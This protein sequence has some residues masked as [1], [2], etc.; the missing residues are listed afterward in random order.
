[1][2]NS[3]YS[4]IYAFGDSLS[5]DGNV[6]IASTLAG[7]P[8]PASPPY[9]LQ[10]YGLFTA[11]E[12]SDGPVWVQDLNGLLGLPTLEPSLFFGNDF[13]Y[14]GA[15]ATVNSGS[16]SGLEQSATSLSSQFVQFQGG[17][18]G[19]SSAL[20]TLSIGTNDLYAILSDNPGTSLST[21][22]NQVGTAVS[23]EMSF[24][25][26]LVGD[27]ARSLLVVDTADVGKLPVITQQNSG[28]QDAL[29]TQLSDL[30]NVELNA[31]LENY[32]QV[33]GVTIS[34]LP[35]ASLE[36]EAVQ[37]P[38][39][40]G[41]SNGTTPAWS[42]N[43]TSAS[44][45]TVAANPNSYVFWDQYHPTEPVQT[46]I[47]QDAQSLVTGGGGTFTAPTFH[48]TDVATNQNSVQYGSVVPVQGSSLQGQFIYPGTDAVAFRADQSNMLLEGGTAAIAMQATGGDNTISGGTGSNF[49]VG[50]TGAD[51]GHDAFYLDLD[52][53]TSGWDTLVNFHTGD[54]LTLWGFDPNAGG[55][56]NWSGVS[57]AAGY[58]GATLT[59]DM[60]GQV[61]SVTFAGLSLAQGE[62]LSSL[63]GTLGSTPY[64]LI[65]NQGV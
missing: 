2:S 39:V 34:I 38:S 55:T 31:D 44:S 62:A 63:T 59:T 24:I 32:A 14:G 15:E 5:D 64:L 54:T 17:G 43:L 45:G 58:A 8:I 11:A 60:S 46:L 4:A 51:G 6:S 20:Y 10:S 12:F 35:L 1:M 18:G 42:G 28:A 48:M 16:L 41:L 21:M 56:M 49:L 40:F 53:V 37:S 13:A 36:D 30:Y 22:M 26:S 19:P 33:N 47:A 50:A 65:G 23:S 52:G 61:R 29:G 7:T 9:Y 3:S 25:S 57:G 27:G